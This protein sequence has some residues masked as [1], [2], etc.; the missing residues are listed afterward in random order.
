MPGAVGEATYAVSAEL[1]LRDRKLRGGRP[2]TRND[3]PGRQ[4]AVQRPRRRRRQVTGVD[5]AAERV[6]QRPHLGRVADPGDVGRVEA[7]LEGVRVPSYDRDAGPQ[8]ELGGRTAD[9]ATAD[10]RAGWHADG[11][12][13]VRV[14]HRGALEKWLRAAPP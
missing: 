8:P 5:A 13:A 4:Q 3:Q 12:V 1:S 7:D 2:G 11:Q 14:I 6:E 9:V 10:M